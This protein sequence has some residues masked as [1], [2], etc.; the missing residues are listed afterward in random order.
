[1]MK[2]VPRVEYIEMLFCCCADLWINPE[3][4]NKSKMCRY[5]NHDDR[6]GHPWL[7]ESG[8][9][10]SECLSRDAILSQ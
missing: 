4:V 3:I 6:N 8:P 9:D 5:F 1:M 2:T 7:D 10:E